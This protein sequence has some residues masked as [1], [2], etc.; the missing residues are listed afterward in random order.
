[1][2]ASVWTFWLTS[3]RAGL[4][5]LRWPCGAAGRPASPRRVGQ[6]RLPQGEG[7]GPRG[8]PSSVTASASRPVSSRAQSSGAPTVA[9]ASTKTGR[10]AAPWRG[11]V[12]DHA[13]QPAQHVRHVR[14]EHAAVAVA[15]VDDD[16][17][18]A[19]GRTRASGRAPAAAPGAACPGWSAGTWRALR[20]Q[21]RSARWSRRRRW[22]PH[23][24]RPE[25]RRPTRA[26][27]RR[28]PW[29]A[30]GRA[31][32]RPSSTAVQRGSQVAQRLAGRG[33]GGR[34]SRGGRP[35][36]AP[37]PGP[38]AST[39]H[40]RRGPRRP[41]RLPRGPRPARADSRPARAG[42]LLHVHRLARLRCTSRAAGRGPRR[43]RSAASGPAGG[44]AA[45][46]A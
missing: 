33:P 20:A 1:M 17:P 37:R 5:P 23:A 22:R 2:K 10:G 44:E 12:R 26:G 43:S 16:E 36:R 41:P 19:G 25:R 4:R 42:M 35:G 14:A 18:Q 13:A 24:G 40:G 29:W 21:A 8:E 45:R 34:G 28:A 30:R 15:L 11:M 38:G 39:G 27:P 3:R 32:C 7:S 6:R 46:W 9:E 31:R